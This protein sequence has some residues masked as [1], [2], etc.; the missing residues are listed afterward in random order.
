MVWILGDPQRR[1]AASL[2]QGDAG[3][4]GKEWIS[5]PQRRAAASLK[6]HLAHAQDAQLALVIRSEELRPH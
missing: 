3:S 6:L 4:A 1:A 5:D 2:K